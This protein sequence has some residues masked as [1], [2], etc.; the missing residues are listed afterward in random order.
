MHWSSSQAFSSSRFL[1]RS[2]G[3]KNRSRISLASRT[4]A[5]KARA[6]GHP[7]ARGELGVE[8]V[9]LLFE[10]ADVLVSLQAL[11]SPELEEHERAVR[12]LDLTEASVAE[13]KEGLDLVAEAIAVAGA[14]YPSNAPAIVSELASVAFEVSVTASDNAADKT[15]QITIEGD[16]ILLTE[17]L[18]LALARALTEPGVPVNI[19]PP[20]IT[21][22]KVESPSAK[23][24][25]QNGRPTRRKKATRGRA[26]REAPNEQ[27]WEN[28]KG[29]YIARLEAKA[30]EALAEATLAAATSTIKHLPKT[31][32]VL[33]GLIYAAIVA[34]PALLAAGGGLSVSLAWIGYELWKR[35]KPPVQILTGRIENPSGRSTRFR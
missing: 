31:I 15:V 35:K 25:V 18:V 2:R 17:N 3:V 5:S 13:A 33:A 24:I 20:I 16:R 26:I 28:L 23:A 10:L 21:G 11:A 22:G 1:N 4:I 8:S 29:R 7:S 30:P 14:P 32:P 6:Y 12:A 34:A 9:S 19:A 27:S